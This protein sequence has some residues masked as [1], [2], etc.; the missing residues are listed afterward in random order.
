ML[1]QSFDDWEVVIGD[2]CSPARDQVR[3]IVDDYSARTN[4]RV[5]CE[6]HA[7]T[8]GY[9]ANLRTLMR[10][11]RGRYVFIIGDDDYVAPNAFRAAADAIARHPNTGM[12]LR[13]F[14]WFVGDRDNVIRITRYYPHEC[15]FPAGRKAILACFRRVVV[16]SGLVIDRDLAAA[17]ETDRWDGS[18]FYQH[19]V[20]GNV[21]AEKD[22][23]YIPDLLVHFRLGSPRSFGTAAAERGLYTPGAEPPETTYKGVYYQLAIAEAIEKERGIPLMSDL[24]RDYANYTYPQFAMHSKAPF[25]EYFQFY[26]RL[27]GLGLARYFGFHAWFWTVALLGAANVE[28]LLDLIRRRVGHT[29]N[30][31]RAMRPE[32]REQRSQGVGTPIR[33]RPSGPAPAISSE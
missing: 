1:A 33:P 2:D 14:A 12:I 22:A 18:L 20:A 5:R 11:A 4:G 19:W 6:F 27:G 30:L 17:C 7:R 8:L 15:V 25:R 26:R 29:P 3:A 21:L 9:D 31:T 28:R 13:A 23:V 24:R 10:L 16:M 32:K